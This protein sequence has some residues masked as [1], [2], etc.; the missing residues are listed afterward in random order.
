LSLQKPDAIVLAG[1]IGH[2]KLTVSPEFYDV[3]VDFLDDISS[4][5]PVIITPGN[6]DGLIHNQSRLDILTPAIKAMDKD[7]IFY[8]KKSDNYDLGFD[9][10]DFYLF[11]CF[12]D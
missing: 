2:D 1:D 9:G 3:L 7:N 11:S 8:L 5:A 6:H 12:D 10:V 4:I